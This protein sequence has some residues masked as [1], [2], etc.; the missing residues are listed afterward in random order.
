MKYQE[1]MT[2]LSVCKVLGI[3]T[4]GELAE[5]KRATGASDNFS[6]LC[7]LEAVARGDNE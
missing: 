3:G 2:L 6:L 5:A 4:L 1:F 7:E